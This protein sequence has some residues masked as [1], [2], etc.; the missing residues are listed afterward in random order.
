MPNRPLD[1]IQDA[2]RNPEIKEAFKSFL[3]TE[4]SDENLEFYE[5]MSQYTKDAQDLQIGDD[6]LRDKARD[7]VNLYILP[8]SE[9]QVNLA[10]FQVTEINTS[11]AGI[12]GASRQQIG[13]MLDNANEEVV[14]MMEK[15]SLRRFQKTP[16]FEAAR[17][18]AN[19]ALDTMEKKLELIQQQERQMKLNPSLGD[20]AKAMVT[21]GG[22]MT[23]IRN[24]ERQREALEKQVQERTPN[25]PVSQKMHATQPTPLPV[26]PPAVARP[27]VAPLDLE[28]GVVGRGRSN[29][30]DSV[31]IPKPDPVKISVRDQLA[32][33]DGTKVAQDKS[34]SVSDSTGDPSS[35]S[36]KDKVKLF[37]QGSG[38]TP[39]KRGMR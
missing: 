37:E 28:P 10:S 9:K 26:A 30:L 35:L 23:M 11:M 14:K 12:D 27:E 34:L 3:K 20:K 32:A 8:G 39:P 4:Y 13:S 24:L 33:K 16:Q 19:H 29:A 7:L 18:E 15:D 25:L 21:S 31:E 1:T 6:Q 17:K 5:R 36:V 38:A 22:M 2:L